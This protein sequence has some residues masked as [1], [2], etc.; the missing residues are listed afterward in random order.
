MLKKLLMSSVLCASS[1]SGVANA[2]PITVDLELQLLADVSGSVNLTEYN[3][4]LEGYSSAFRSSSVIDSILAG[5]IGSIAVQYIEWSGSA[6]QAVQ[7]DWML[8]DSAVSSIAF[9]DL[10]DAT[11]R[12][13]SG[14]TAIGSAIDFGD[15]L[16]FNNN[17]EAARQVMD[18]SGDGTQ[19]DGSD[20]S[21]ARDAALALGV[22][23]INGITIGGT[24]GLED[25]YTNNV[26]GGVNPFQLHADTFGD[27]EAG[28]EAKLIREIGPNPIPEPASIALLGLGLLGLG[29]RRKA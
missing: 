6:Q 3:L 23:T 10:L 26:I 16:F 1:F 21:D 29:F 27:F 13:F 2:M 19:N 28:I 7:V 4:Q 22:D 17:Y 12:S 25:F 11:T 9:A 24:S 20:T 5:T 18:V 14:S 15:D 8:I